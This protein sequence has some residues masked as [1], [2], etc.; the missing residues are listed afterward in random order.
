[1]NV[2]T[3]KFRAVGLL[4]TLAVLMG[5]AVLPQIAAAQTT[6]T[7][8]PAVKPNRVERPDENVDFLQPLSCK[9]ESKLR[10]LNGDQSTTIRLINRG[11]HTYKVYW[12]DYQGHRK[13]YRDLA[14]GERYDQ[15]TYVTH[16]WVITEAGPEQR[17]RG[18]F[19]PKATLGIIRLP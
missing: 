1:M 5:A 16:P 10:S 4:A 15:Q 12:L 2:L 11:S 17:C 9:A 13:H 6:P 14:P 18:I 7:T 3:A 8:T 19:Q